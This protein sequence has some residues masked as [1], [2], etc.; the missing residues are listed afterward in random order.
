[1]A[2]ALAKIG[3]R[4]R[5]EFA[6]NTEYKELDSFRYKRSTY[7]AK[8]DFTSG[9]TFEE[10]ADN[11]QVLA[12]ATGVE[13]ATEAAKAAAELAN[14]NGTEVGVQ[15]EAAKRAAEEAE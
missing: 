12:D 7:F 4:D 15:A 3:F 5:G 14:Q 11:V 8:K 6:P 2:K 13:E 9:A 10:T 1:M